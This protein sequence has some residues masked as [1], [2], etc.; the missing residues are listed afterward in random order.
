MSRRDVPHQRRM[1]MYAFLIITAIVMLAF[2]VATV[3]G[4]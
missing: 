3:V 2:V 1:E 4:R